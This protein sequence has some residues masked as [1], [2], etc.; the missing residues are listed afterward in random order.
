MITVTTTDLRPEGHGPGMSPVPTRR[1]RRDARRRA[2]RRQGLR[3]MAAV[4]GS[5]ALLMIGASAWSAGVRHGTEDPEV[6]STPS[7]GASAVAPM[8]SAASTTAAAPVPRTPGQPRPSTRSPTTPNPVTPRATP[9][10]TTP[11]P[12]ASTQSAPAP[13]VAPSEAPTPVMAAPQVT[14]LACAATGSAAVLRGSAA[15]GSAPVTVVMSL[16]GRSQTRYAPAGSALSFSMSATPAP[17]GSAC[18]VTVASSAGQG[19]VTAVVR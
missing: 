14:G 7:T 4:V 10:G 9:A 11:S 5:A 1:D 6:A 16:G 19:R 2:Q 15:A 18:S 13:R 17:V 12:P 8:T 3:R